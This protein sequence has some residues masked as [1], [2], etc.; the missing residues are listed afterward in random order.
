MRLSGRTDVIDIP[1]E[2]A[3]GVAEPATD[4]AEEP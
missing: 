4:S 2:P 3:D 1:A